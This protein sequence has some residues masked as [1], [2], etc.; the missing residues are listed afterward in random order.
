MLGLDLPVVPMLHQYVVTDTV[1]EIAERIAAGAGELPIIRD[2]EES[3]YLR[4]ERDG[5]IVGPYERAAEPWAVDGVPAGF[6]MELLPPDLE[7]IEPIIALAMAR[8][9]ALADAGIKTLVNGPITFTPDANPLIG[10]AFGLRNAWLLTG[11]SM[12]VMEGGGAG[13]FLADWIV[14]GAPRSDPLAVDPRR[15][16]SYA[17]RDYRVAKAVEGFGLQFGIHYPY[18]ERPA[19]HGRAG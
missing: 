10:P 12:G 8:A 1:A 18:E 14:D 3:W 9:P 2:P 7:R 6:G 16:G 15:F 11:S 5:Y 13:R 17:D 4:Q 19:G